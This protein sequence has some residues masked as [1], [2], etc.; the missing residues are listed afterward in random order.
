MDDRAEIVHRKP[1][2]DR[3][4]DL[5]DDLDSVHSHDRRAEETIRGCVSVELGKP[6]RL[7]LAERLAVAE[8]AR[9]AQL[10]VVTGCLRGLRVQANHGYFR[11]RVDAR[12]H[13]G[14]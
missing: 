1:V 11:V 14:S 2:A 8:V 13:H 12:G 3:D 9:L 10:D 6:V 7:A 5:V 4:S